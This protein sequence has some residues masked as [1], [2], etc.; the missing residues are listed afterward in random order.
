MSIGSVVARSLDV[1]LFAKACG[2]EPDFWQADFLRSKAK[3]IIL[4]CSRQSGKSTVAA[5]RALHQAIY[6]PRSLTLILGPSQRQSQELFS[7]TMNFYS[8]L[9]QNERPSVKKRTALE[10]E[11]VTGSRIIALPENESTVRGYAS[12]NLIII[13]E[14]A[15]VKDSYYMTIRPMLVVSKGMIIALSTPRS[16]NGWFYETWTK[17]DNDWHKIKI[18]ARECPRITPEILEQE[19]KQMPSYMFKMEYECEFMDN[20]YQVISTELIKAAITPG[21]D[22]TPL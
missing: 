20:E 16:R 7:K 1:V 18:T 15:Y 2:I 22:W 9:P 12:V 14:A 5:L 17:N 21:L 11:F 3:Q 4:L 10:V 19:R 6:N 13:D 8:R